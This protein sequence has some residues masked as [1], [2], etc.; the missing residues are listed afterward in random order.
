MA[1]QREQLGCLMPRLSNPHA[2]G[3]CLEPAP[4]NPLGNSLSPPPLPTFIFCFKNT[5]ETKLQKGHLIN[6][7][8]MS[9]LFY[10]RHQISSEGVEEKNNAALKPGERFLLEGCTEASQHTCCLLSVNKMPSQ[11]LN[12]ARVTSQSLTLRLP[13]LPMPLDKAHTLLIIFAAEASSLFAAY[14][15]LFVPAGFITW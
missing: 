6:H 10:H 13:L 12:V 5:T 8:L 2:T 15:Y 7:I 9:N 11:H 1:G 4:K 3:S 14:K